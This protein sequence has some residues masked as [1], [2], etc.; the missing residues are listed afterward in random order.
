MSSLHQ[1][2]ADLSS[3]RLALL[4]QRVRERKGAGP[5]SEIPRRPHSLDPAPLSFAQQRMWFLDQLE[6]SLPSGDVRG[7]SAGEPT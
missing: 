1:R 2:I 7:V 3:D 4:V 5:E 6:L